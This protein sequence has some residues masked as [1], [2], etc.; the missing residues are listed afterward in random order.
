MNRVLH[1]W[2]KGKSLKLWLFKQT[3]S[4]HLGQP[5][6]IKVHL[7]RRPH[8]YQTDRDAIRTTRRKKEKTGRLRLLLILAL[9]S[10]CVCVFFFSSFPPA[11][12]AQ[13]QPFHPVREKK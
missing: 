12:D 7:M 2:V 5:Y 10:V 4:L 9:V 1:G 3:E 6:N 8:S 13:Q 11:C